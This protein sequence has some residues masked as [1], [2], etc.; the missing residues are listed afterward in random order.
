MTITK[1]CSTF[2]F[3]LRVPDAQVGEVEKVLASHEAWMQT[4]RSSMSKISCNSA[5]HQTSS[6]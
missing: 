6:T 4:R 1:N 5:W 3:M 2:N